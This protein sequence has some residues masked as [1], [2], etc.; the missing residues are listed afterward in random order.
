MK[1]CYDVLSLNSCP[2][3]K[4]EQDDKLVYIMFGPD[5][6]TFKHFLSL[7]DLMNYANSKNLIPD[8]KNGI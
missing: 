5:L 3:F 8:L 2:V 4:V 6:K 1:S 7:E